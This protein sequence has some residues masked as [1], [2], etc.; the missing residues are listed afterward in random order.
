MTR[1][2]PHGVTQDEIEHFQAIDLARATFQDP[3]FQIVAGSRHF[4]PDHSH[5]LTGKTWNTPETIPHLISFFR[6]A[7]GVS[8]ERLTE[9]NRGELRRFYTFGTDLNAHTGFL[10]GGVVAALLDS[11]VSN[12]CALHSGLT[13][14]S[15]G[16]VFT[17][18]LNIS[19][20]KPVPTPGTA[21]LRAWTTTQPDGR[22]LWAKGAVETEGVVHAVCEGLWLIVRPKL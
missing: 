2:L 9:S 17:L 3:H 11:A 18:Q 13:K 15:G 14:E 21:M 10:H 19:F 4:T 16:T 5:T 1:P 12:F 8:Q 20:K 6:P 7:N 22:K